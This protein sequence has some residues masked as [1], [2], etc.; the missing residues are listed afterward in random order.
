VIEG[1][2]NGEDAPYAN[3]I[4][5]NGQVIS[6]LY[7]GQ[8]E[9]MKGGTISFDMAKEPIA[10]SYDAGDLPFSLSR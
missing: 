1:I 6:R 10:R 4:K 5:L 9:I 2:G 8:E 3:Q 7:V